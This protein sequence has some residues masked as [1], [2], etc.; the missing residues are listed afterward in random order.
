MKRTVRKWM[1]L[2]DLSEYIDD[3]KALESKLEALGPDDD[4]A[5]LLVSFPLATFQG[6]QAGTIPLSRLV[7][8]E[9]D[10]LTAY[11][12]WT[13]FPDQGSIQ[14]QYFPSKNLLELKSYK[15]YLLA[16]RERHITQEHLAQ[17]IY[18]DLFALLTPLR[19]QVTLDYMPRGGIHT[20]FTLDS[21]TE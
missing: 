16:F 10:E 18:D 21:F 7:R 8:C 3:Y 19:L 17:K 4:P 6:N 2:P 11:C 15:F 9:Y 14:M 1:L 20:T 12:P 5:S 13:R